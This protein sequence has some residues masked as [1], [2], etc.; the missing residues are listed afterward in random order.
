MAPDPLEGFE[1]YPART[2]MALLAQE[3]RSQRRMMIGVARQ[4]FWILTSFVGLLMTLIGGLSLIILVGGK[5]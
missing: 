5:P 3:L 2:Q 1:D 4:Q